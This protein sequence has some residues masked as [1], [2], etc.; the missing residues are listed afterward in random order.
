MLA[1]TER[2]REDIMVNG[3]GFPRIAEE[4]L[5]VPIIQE[6]IEKCEREDYHW[7][8]IQLFQSCED[9]ISGILISDTTSVTIF[10]DPSNPDAAK[11]VLFV[12]GFPFLDGKP[13]I[14][15]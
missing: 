14:Q 7:P 6:M 11:E 8:Y 5:V 1:V 4:H 2:N 3:M 13:L 12:Q 15:Y 10:N 9:Q